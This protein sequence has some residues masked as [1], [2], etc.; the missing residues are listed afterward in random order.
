[1]W[2]IK[3]SSDEAKTKKQIHQTKKNLN[4]AETTNTVP[5]TP[6]QIFLCVQKSVNCSLWWKS[7]PSQLLNIYVTSSLWCL[8]HVI[9]QPIKTR[10]IGIWRQHL[11]V[12]NG[13]TV[14]FIHLQNHMAHQGYNEF[15]LVLLLFHF[16]ISFGSKILILIIHYLR[17]ET[18][19]IKSKILWA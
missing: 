14:H 10:I 5:H 7:F 8:V 9:L 18:T 15:D 13:Q 19:N 2:Q 6:R 16:L 4:S 11:T 3:K 17:Y 1:M 12:M